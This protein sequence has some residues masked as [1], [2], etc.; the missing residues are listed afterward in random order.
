MSIK[1]VII[2]DITNPD[3]PTL[4]DVLMSVPPL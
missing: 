4:A 3:T 2:D 1:N